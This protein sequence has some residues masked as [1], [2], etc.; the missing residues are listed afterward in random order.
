[1]NWQEVRDIASASSNPKKKRVR[2]AD[3][4]VA[5]RGF[6]IGMIKDRDSALHKVG[7]I[8]IHHSLRFMAKQS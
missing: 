6:T 2:F 7:M 4:E 1:V 5:A 8:L 3:E